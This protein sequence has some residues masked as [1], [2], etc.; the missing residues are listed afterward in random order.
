MIS[1]PNFFISTR[2]IHTKSEKQC[3]LREDLIPRVLPRPLLHRLN[4]QVDLFSQNVLHQTF[5]VSGRCPVFVYCAGLPAVETFS[6]KNHCVMLRGE[7]T[8]RACFFFLRREGRTLVPRH[9]LRF[10]YDS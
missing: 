4:P 3:A 9:Q 5:P 7:L 8:S 10:S 2:N 6:L 1:K